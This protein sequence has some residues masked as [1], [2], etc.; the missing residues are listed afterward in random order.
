MSLDATRWAWDQQNLRPSEKLVLLSLA[1]RAGEDHTSWPG[2]PRL[3]LDTGLDERS[4]YRAIKTL[5][6]HGLIAV[7]K[8]IKKGKRYHNQYILVGVIG[9]EDDRNKNQ[10]DTPPESHLTESH[11]TESHHTPDRMSAISLTECHPNLLR[12]PIMESKRSKILSLGSL[13]NED[14][15]HVS[16]DG[17]E[18]DKDFY[19][20]LPGLEFLELRE[21][22]NEHARPEAPR[23]GFIEYKHL[24]VSRQWPGFGRI[25]D[26]INAHKQAAPEWWKQFC[27]GLAKFL[28][29]HWWDMTPNF[30]DLPNR[31]PPSGSTSLAQR[32]A[33]TFTRVIKKMED[34][35]VGK[36]EKSHGAHGTG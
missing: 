12:E 16:E 5:T 22:Y 11:L 20:D 3:V 27:P 32:N 17:P 14:R 8:T 29:E 13:E 2:I 28:R 1:D 26:S 35:H 25:Q 18:R 34:V 24:R 36:D 7:T 33:E 4:I 9:R 23:A 6:D 10:N 31:D 15:A 21:H 19:A 30:R